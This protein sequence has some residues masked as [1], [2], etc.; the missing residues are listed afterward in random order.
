[1]FEN[2][3]PIVNIFLLSLMASLGTGLGGLIAVIRNLADAPTAFMGTHR[4]KC[5]S[6]WLSWN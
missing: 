6:A 5:R 3:H 2:L 4:Q 1:M